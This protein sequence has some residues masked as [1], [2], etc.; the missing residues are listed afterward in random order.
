M[1]RGWRQK[2]LERSL[3]DQGPIQ[4]RP[5]HRSFLHLLFTTRKNIIRTISPSRDLGHA[6]CSEKIRNRSGFLIVPDYSGFLF[7]SVYSLSR[8]CRESESGPMVKGG[9]LLKRWTQLAATPRFQFRGSQ[10]TLLA[11]LRSPGFEHA[12][13]SWFGPYIPS[14]L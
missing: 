13:C 3:T 1:S 12:C 11:P 2:N 4:E 8:D 6:M 5:S 9:E 7:C 14:R 10:R